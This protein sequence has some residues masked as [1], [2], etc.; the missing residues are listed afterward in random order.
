MTQ[1][2]GPLPVADSQTGLEILRGLGRERSLLAALTLMHRYVGRTF[3]IAPSRFRP[4][5]FAGPES[6]RQILVSDR[7]TLQWRPETNPRDWPPTLRC[8]RGGR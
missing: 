5:G 2:A 3:Q 8:A 7:H 6:N 4:A 1:T